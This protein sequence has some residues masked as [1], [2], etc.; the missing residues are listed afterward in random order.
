MNATAI[1]LLGYIGWFL[2][3]LGGIAV[4]RLTVSLSQG[5]PAN[6]FR[7][8]G[9]DVSPFSARLCG[10]HTNGYESFPFMGGLLLLAL[11]TNNTAVTDPLALA[12]LA[13]RIAQ[14][15]VNLVS[16]SVG[17]VQIRFAFFLVQFFIAVYWT[18][19]LSARLAGI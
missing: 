13:S 18:I 11:A 19:Q 12:A 8:D 4:F 2:L 6:S 15:S 14:S 7:P 3:L 9:A 1:A 17:A 16:T 10:A 5:K